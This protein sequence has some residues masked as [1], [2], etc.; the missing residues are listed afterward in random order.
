MWLEKIIASELG[1]SN[2]YEVYQNRATLASRRHTMLAAYIYKHYWGFT[3]ADIAERLHIDMSR[4]ANVLREAKE[5]IETDEEM[6]ELLATIIEKD[7]E[8][9]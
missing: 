5:L 7:N 6:A 3:S 1:Y 9:R 2:V 8:F 4:V